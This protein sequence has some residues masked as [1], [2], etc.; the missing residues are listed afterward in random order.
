MIKGKQK[1]DFLLVKG[2]CGWDKNQLEAEVQE[3]SW[4]IAV[5][6]YKAIFSK[7]SHASWDKIIKSIGVKKSDNIVSYSGRA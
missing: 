2:F 1:D 7:K 3:N 5:A 4:L 6:D